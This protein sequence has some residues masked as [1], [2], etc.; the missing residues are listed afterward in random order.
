[1][2]EQRTDFSDLV[3]ERRAE[4][5]ISLRE[6]ESRSIDPKPEKGK[7]PEQAKFGWISKVEKGQSVDTPSA[8]LL[9]ALHVGL[10][11]PLRILQE[12]AAAQFLEMDS[13]LWSDDRTTRVLVARAEELTEEDRR[14]LLDI[15]ETF[16][17]R[18][19]QSDERAGD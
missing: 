19:T 1:M 7:A 15:A 10:Q 8:G 16:A 13:S 17:R 6:L 2:A 4:L 18:R 12:A 14:Q 9:R 5:G 3:R 11:L